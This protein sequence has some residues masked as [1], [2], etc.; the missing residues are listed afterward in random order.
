ITPEKILPGDV[1]IV[2]AHYGG[3]DQFG[4]DPD[5]NEP[6]A[7][8]ADKASRP[9][10]GRHFTVRVAP[11]LVGEDESVVALAEALV[12]S[13]SDGWQDIRNAVE[14][15]SLPKDLKEALNAL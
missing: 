10:S 11:G 1:I 6:V 12:A 4:W 8:V 5:L 14:G 7:D 2:P 15:L 9:F 3:L 13:P